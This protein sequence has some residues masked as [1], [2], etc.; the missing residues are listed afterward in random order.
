MLSKINTKKIVCLS[1]LCCGL[2]AV[3]I[4]VLFFAVTLCFSFVNCQIVHNVEAGD[5]L[6]CCV[7][8]CFVLICSIILVNVHTLHLIVSAMCPGFS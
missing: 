4:S 7:C 8:S 1:I 3:P 5:V 2:R 6:V